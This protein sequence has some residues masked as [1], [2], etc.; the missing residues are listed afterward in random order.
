MNKSQEIVFRMAMENLKKA[1]PRLSI[2]SG[3]ALGL[4]KDKEGNTVENKYTAWAN[5]SDEMS[6][7]LHEAIRLFQ[8]VADECMLN[9]T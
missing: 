9:G 4:H 6:N 3:A 7:E 2:I 5:E 8:I 1:K